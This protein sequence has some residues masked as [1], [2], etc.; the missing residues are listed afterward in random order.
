MRRLDWQLVHP[1]GDGDLDESMQLLVMIR[2]LATKE[3]SQGLSEDEIEF[4]G[5]AEESYYEG[6]LAHCDAV[7]APLVEQDPDWETRIID[8]YAES[9]EDMELEDYLDIRRR[10]PDCDRCPFASPYSLYPMDRCE[11][12]AG[13][14]EEVLTD[15]GLR[16][17]LAE[18]M[19]PA[20]MLAL[21]TDLEATIAAGTWREIDAVDTRDYLNKAVFFLRFWAEY[22]FGILPTDVDEVVDF[23]EQRDTLDPEDEPPVFH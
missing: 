12:S 17:R 19:Q 8:E 15:E 5:G 21:A 10:E 3:A 9:Q 20:Q 11:F 4:L 13:A 2:R 14:L 6:T 16:A 22:G 18:P 7:E 23:P 1:D